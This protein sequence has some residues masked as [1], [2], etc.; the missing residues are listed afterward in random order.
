MRRLISSQPQS[1]TNYIERSEQL[2]EEHRIHKKIKD[3]QQMWDT[4]S[5]DEREVRLNKIDAEV[6]SLLLSTEKVY[7]KLR[8]GVVSYSPELSK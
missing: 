4:W 8:I 2:F 1:V 6:T 5:Q 3:I 7:R